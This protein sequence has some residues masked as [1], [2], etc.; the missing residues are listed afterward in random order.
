MELNI[1]KDLEYK[2]EELNAIIALWEEA[3]GKFPNK[4]IPFTSSTGRLF[5][6]VSYL[7]GACS[8]KTYRGEPAMRLEALA[9]Q[10]NPENVPLDRDE[11]FL[12]NSSSMVL[13]IIDLL[14]DNRIK[15]EDIACKFQIEIAKSFAKAAITEARIKNI[16]YIGLTGGVAYNYSFST[17]IKNEVKNA[18]LRFLEHDI[19][20]PGDA[21][22]SIGQLIGGIY[23]YL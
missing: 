9:S 13:D 14:N 7:L 5:D 2:T 21:G 11:Y 23:R 8:I 1:Q 3:N 20:P 12:R 19:I 18:G 16:P 6:T 17:T 10:G 15:R 22:I 4:N